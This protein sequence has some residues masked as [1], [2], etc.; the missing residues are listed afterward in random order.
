LFLLNCGPQLVSLW[1]GTYVL[2]ED[3]KYTLSAKVWIAIGQE[4]FV[5]SR[6]LPA[7][8]GG[9]LPNIATSWGLYC[10]ESWCFWLVSIGPILLCGQL[11]KKY[12]NHYMELMAII[13]CLPLASNTTARIEQ[14]QHEII[15]YVE[16]FEE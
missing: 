10:G 16:K 13:K 1:A 15:H 6:T 9:L 5:A 11:P 12:Y 7:A 14:L 8:F 3:D 4:T 2:G